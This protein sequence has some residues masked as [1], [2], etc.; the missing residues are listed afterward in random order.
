MHIILIIPILK[1]RRLRIR[2]VVGFAPGSQGWTAREQR[3]GLRPADP[4]AVHQSPDPQSWE[5]SAV[6]PLGVPTEVA[7][8]W[9][10]P[11]PWGDSMPAGA[12][13]ATGISLL[14]FF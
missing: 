4:R 2:E 3:W 6:S 5:L 12:G 14:G 10:Q 8:D 11:G 9:P 1:M 13:W 7:L